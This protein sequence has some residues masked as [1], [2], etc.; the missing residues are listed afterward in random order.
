MAFVS[1]I[2]FTLFVQFILYKI[3]EDEIKEKIKD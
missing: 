2:I 1:G 3:F